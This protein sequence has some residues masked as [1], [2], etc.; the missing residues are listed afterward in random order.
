MPFTELLKTIERL[1]A[2][3]QTG[4]KWI[5]PPVFPFLAEGGG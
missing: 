2:T 1:A 4:D 3:R 5:P